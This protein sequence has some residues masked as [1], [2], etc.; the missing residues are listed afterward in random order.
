[1]HKHISPDYSDSP[2]GTTSAVISYSS[3]GF[4]LS[5]GF[6]K[7]QDLSGSKRHW[8]L[9]DYCATSSLQLAFPT[10]SGN[11]GDQASGGASL[12]TGVLIGVLMGV[13]ALIALIGGLVFVGL[14]R[15]R[16]DDSEDSE[17][18]DE[19]PDVPTDANAFTD[20]DLGSI[21]FENQ[22]EIDGDDGEDGESTPGND[23]SDWAE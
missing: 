9:N 21:V 11:V 4:R 13:I 22:L 15:K 17:E 3:I 2:R 23:G 6:D 12:S 5:N 18:M 7:S 16:N 10:V 8:I 14:R 1:L 19:D 20:A